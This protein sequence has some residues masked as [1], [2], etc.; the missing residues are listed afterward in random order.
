M[1]SATA[2]TAVVTTIVV[3]GASRGFGRALA[4]ALAA[5]LPKPMHMVCGRA[6]LQPRELRRP[7]SWPSADA[8]GAD[9]AQ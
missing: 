5:A 2:A 8:A 7:A 1:S 6:M 4:L 3:T 9:G